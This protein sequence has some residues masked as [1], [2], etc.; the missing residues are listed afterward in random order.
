MITEIKGDLFTTGAQVILHGCNCQGKMGSGV[1]KAV[2][3]KYPVVFD[4]YEELH[5]TRGLK[6]GSILPVKVG[7]D[8]WV[9][10]CMT[11]KFYGYDGKQYVSYDAV[12]EC[13]H[14]VASM[15]S[16]EYKIAMP[17]IGC[18]LAGGDWEVV[19]KIVEDELKDFEVLVYSL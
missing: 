8:K 11:Q 12:W 14:R 10:N 3:E 16:K 6:L 1:A 18:G 4:E 9:V 7:K 5:R 19:R 2:R 15:A 17:K 13:L